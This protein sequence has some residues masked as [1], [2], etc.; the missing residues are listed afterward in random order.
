[1]VLSSFLLV[2]PGLEASRVLVWQVSWYLFQLFIGSTDYLFGIFAA[3]KLEENDAGLWEQMLVEKHASGFRQTANGSVLPHTTPHNTTADSSC[4]WVT[5]LIGERQ[6]L[7]LLRQGGKRG[8]WASSASFCTAS[9]T[10]P[11]AIDG[12]CTMK[13]SILRVF[14]CAH[15]QGQSECSFQSQCQNTFEASGMLSNQIL[16]IILFARFPFGPSQQC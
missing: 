2:N 13:G 6:R 15:K 5:G 8:S 11:N 1:M 7:G 14:F 10:K 12:C 16:R 4:L 3:S 9:I